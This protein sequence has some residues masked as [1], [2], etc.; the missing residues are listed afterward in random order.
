MAEHGNVITYYS[1][2]T[3]GNAL[4]HARRWSRSTN[5]VWKKWLYGW[6]APLTVNNYRKLR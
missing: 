2:T 3:Y 5:D 1:Q 6:K 4:F